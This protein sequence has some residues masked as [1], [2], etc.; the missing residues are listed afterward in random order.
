MSVTHV[1][2]DASNMK[3]SD[4]KDIIDYINRY[5]I[6]LNNIFSLVGADS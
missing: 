5:Q 6:A 3:L 1:F 2:V 4:Y